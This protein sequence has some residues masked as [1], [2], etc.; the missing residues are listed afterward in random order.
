V[1]NTRHKELL[2]RLIENT[3]GAYALT[4]TGRE[5]FGHLKPLGDWAMDWVPSLQPE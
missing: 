5:L 1:L 2:R 3:A 4:A